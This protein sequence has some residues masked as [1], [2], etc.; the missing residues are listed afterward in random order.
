MA[1]RKP[2]PDDKLAYFTKR[3][4]GEKG[5]VMVW[6]FQNEEIA[7]IEYTCP[8]CE[9]TGEKQQPFVREKMSVKD[10][11][12]GK[13]KKKDVFRFVCDFCSQNIDIEKWVKKMGRKAA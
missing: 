3:T 8:H 2:G 1:L 7:N 12:T 11:K 6:R 5:K 4:L 10:P 9:K 13:S